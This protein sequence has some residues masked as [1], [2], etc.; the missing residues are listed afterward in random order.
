MSAML[1]PVL[2]GIERLL[3]GRR[4]DNSKTIQDKDCNNQLSSEIKAM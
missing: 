1:G 3:L 2:G 4:S